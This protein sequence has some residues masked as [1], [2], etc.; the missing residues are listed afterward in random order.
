MDCCFLTRKRKKRKRRGAIYPTDDEDLLPPLPIKEEKITGEYLDLFSK[1]IIP[2][3]YCKEKFPLGS[4]ELKV[5]CNICNQFFH[6]GIA[7]ECIGKDCCLL[8]PEN[9]VIHRSKYCIYCVSKIYSH[10]KGKC[11]CKDCGKKKH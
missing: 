3:G 9:N 11:L 10:K 5:H 7:G 2:C 1:E 4:G 8:D 6:C